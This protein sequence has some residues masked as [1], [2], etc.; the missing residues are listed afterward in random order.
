MPSEFSKFIK[1]P[2]LFSLSSHSF[3]GCAEEQIADQ[4]MGG[5]CHSMLIDTSFLPLIQISNV[6]FKNGLRRRC[7]TLF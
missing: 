7:I 2:I 4:L 6:S 5:H 3:G 1:L